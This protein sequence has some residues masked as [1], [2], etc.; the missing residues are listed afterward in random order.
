ME[1]FFIEFPEVSLFLFW[2]VLFFGGARIIRFPSLAYARLIFFA[3][4][5]VGL[6]V[7]AEIIRPT[8]PI[9]GAAVAALILVIV[10]R[11]W[12]NER[13]KQNESPVVF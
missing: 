8:H 9:L 5:G 11:C 13:K 10:W 2:A 3:L 6:V 1:A 4:F 12:L 7:G